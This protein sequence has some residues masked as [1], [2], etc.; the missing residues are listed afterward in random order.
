[1]TVRG[2]LR[3]KSPTLQRTLATLRDGR[4]WWGGLA[5]FGLASLGQDALI[6]RN[7]TIAAALLYGAAIIVLILAFFRLSWPNWPNHRAG[8]QASPIMPPSPDAFDLTSKARLDLWVRWRA[9]RAR[10]GHRA[11]V[12]GLVITLVLASGTG[13]VL[14]SHIDNPLGGW[15][16]AATLVAL[17]ATFAGAPP[18]S[19]SRALLP[20]PESDSV[21]A[22]RPDVAWRW[23]IILVGIILGL[24]L[25]LRLVNLEYMP[26][27][28]GDEGERGM[29]ARAINEG[30]H[31][32]IFGYGWYSV[33]NLYFYILAGMLRLFGDNVTGAR[34]L[35]VF[36]GVA[37]VWIIYRIGRLLWGT[38]TGLI[39]GTMLAVSP[40]A[41]QFS[42][43]A[44]ESTPTGTLWAAGFLFLFQ[45]LRHRRPFDWIA[46][47]ICWGFSLYFYASGKLI[48]PLIALL[49]LYGLIRW[50][51]EFIR[52]HGV[53]LLA[54]LLAFGLTFLPGAIFSGQSNWQGFTGRAQETSIFAAP[55][56][57]AVFAAAGVPYD[58]AWATQPLRQS[59]LDH[60]LAWARVLFAQLHATVEALYR[61]GDP[62]AFFQIQAHGGSLLSP[63]WAAL[64]ILGLAY[65]AWR[66]WDGRF[67]LINLWFWGGMS[68]AVLTTNAPSVQRLVGAWPPLMLFPAIVLDMVWAAAWPL[69]V[70]L[71]RRWA[72]APLAALVVFFGVDSYHE[73]FIH[74]AS[75]CPYCNATTQAHYAEALGQVYKAYQ[76]GVG[77]DI[78]FGYGS[79]RFVAKGVEG[80]DL[81]VP[82]DYFPLTDNNGKGAAFLIYP[83]NVDYLPLIRLFYP[84]GKE[85]AIKSADGVV[86]FTSYK[87]TAARIAAAQT[88]R[89][90]YTLPDGQTLRQNEPNIGT[91]R[92]PSSTGVTWSPPAGLTY[93]ARAVWQGGLVAPVYG[94]YQFLLTGVGA[95][96]VDGR[97]V[98]GTRSIA[99]AVATPSMGSVTLAR[100]IHTVR[101]SGVLPHAGAG[102]TVQWK[103]PNASSDPIAITAAYL[104]QGPTGGLS[105]G[106]WPYTPGTPLSSDAPFDQTRPITRRRDPFFGFREATATFGQSPFAVRW[107]GALI[108]PN[109]GTYAFELR[110]NGPSL[111][112]IDGRPVVTNGSDGAIGIASATLP[113]SRGRHT[114]DLRYAWH[115]GPARLEWYW[116]PP[117]GSHSLVPPTALAPHA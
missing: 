95:L 37:A 5:A 16:W 74:Y 117:G 80:V 8:T 42:R 52:R 15:L 82:A 101:L 1:M 11:T 62:T 19:S 25:V 115:A 93:P 30:S 12:V 64:A 108:A 53:G 44:S 112:L 111:L 105:G 27:V 45:A 92:A 55:N 41:L 21:A 51:A 79:T 46:A 33:P 70:V 63:L 69:S 56:Q 87:V 2:A 48:I 96:E 20:W 113:L 83:S 34:L 47:G 7:D 13:A 84:G 60:L 40:V 116:T 77:D 110:S 35:S 32:P 59:M 24:A 50:R 4:G 39:A 103:P 106:G 22:G 43:Q 17:G 67:G 36:S 71:A 54:L 23:R 104:Y 6:T 90:S 76:L 100:G 114:V 85:E 97:A 3:V 61:H 89:A 10:L 14:W 18:A 31:D 86:H 73:Y 49:V 88:L 109:G 9:R 94:R 26:G 72:T 81:A 38:R 102:L 29:D 107:Q 75:L 68:A 57:P 58:P 28:F 98:L 99:A 66:T 78:Y 91:A 65:A